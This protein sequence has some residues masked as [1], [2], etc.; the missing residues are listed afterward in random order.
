M[1]KIYVHRERLIRAAA[2]DGWTIGEK[3]LLVDCQA[4]R[5]P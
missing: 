3:R 4:K 5:R 2:A 1:L